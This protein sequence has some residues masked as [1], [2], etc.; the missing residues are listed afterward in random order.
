M[1]II[2]ILLLS[3]NSFYGQSSVKNE[4]PSS[5][6]LSLSAQEKISFV[7]GA[8]SALSV[9]KNEHK[10]EVAKQYLHDKNW[11]EPYYIERYYSVIDE[12]YSE[13]VGY[14]IQ[15]ITMHMDAF[16]ANS[17]NLNIPIMDALKVVS[18]IQDGMREKAN[19]RLLQLQ[20]KY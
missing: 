19:L 5:F 11:I 4:Y 20:R 1:K 10:K 12:Y 18:L 8:Y 6:W 2:I 7:N 3:I 16:Y 9:L 15:I 14:D 17:D 13:K